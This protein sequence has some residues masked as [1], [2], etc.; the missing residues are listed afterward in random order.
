MV[1][2]NRRQAL[3][4]LKKTQ[5]VIGVSVLTALA[6]FSLNAVAGGFQLF[7]ENVTNLGNAYAGSGAEADDA[8]TEFFNPAGMTRLDRPQVVMSGTYLDL[9]NVDVNV[10]NAYTTSTNQ[11]IIDGIPIS[12]PNTTQITGQTNMHPGVDATIPSFHFVYP[13]CHKWALGFGATVPFGLETI[14][15]D[16]AAIRN[17]ATTSAVQTVDIGPSLAYQF[18]QHFSLGA[19]IDSQYMSATFDQ[20]VPDPLGG[21]GSLGS[22]INEG[23]SWGWGWHAGALYQFDPSTR[24]G[25]TYHSAVKHQITGR[26]IADLTIGPLPPVIDNPEQLDLTGNFVSNV[27]LPDYADLSVYHDINSQWAVLGSLDYTQWSKIKTLTAYYSG[28]IGDAIPFANLPFDFRDTYRIAGGVNYKPAPKWTVRTGLAWD[29]SPVT[30]DATRTFRLP[31][32]DRIWV[33]LGAQ[34]I[35][36]PEFTIDA[37]YTH[38][39]VMSNSI[40]NSQQVGGNIDLPFIDTNILFNSVSTGVANVTS[41][42]NEFGAQLTWNI[43]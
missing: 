25:L 8:S 13:F 18:N 9:N 4:K 6:G 20:A 11:I 2:I 19:G 40:N 16:D 32:S 17:L 15:P 24:V 12:L 38:L 5:T 27:T 23:D 3:S 41:N 1:N 14:Y 10:K 31:D 29:E 42:V 43:I 34:Y 39:F 22:F 28:T 21:S 35:I 36:N 37:G 33:G 26:A 30:S 7:E